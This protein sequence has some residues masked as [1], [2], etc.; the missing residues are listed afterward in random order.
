MRRP[1]HQ[2]FYSQWGALNAYKGNCIIPRQ[3][4]NEE[5]QITENINDFIENHLDWVFI[6]AIWIDGICYNPIYIEEGIGILVRVDDSWQFNITGD[7]CLSL[8]D[9]LRPDLPDDIRLKLKINLIVGKSFEGSIPNFSAYGYGW[10]YK[11]MKNLLSQGLLFLH[12]DMCLHSFFR[13]VN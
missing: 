1:Y 2:Y 12:S 7:N 9:D 6:E 4:E 13:K 3:E 10:E 11:N 5:I 8:I